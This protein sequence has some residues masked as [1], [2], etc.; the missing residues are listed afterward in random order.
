LNRSGHGIFVTV[1]QTDL[2]GRRKSNIQRIRAVFADLDGVPLEPVYTCKLEPH[3]VVESSPGNYHPYWFVDELPLNLFKP[4]QKTIQDRFDGDAVIDRSRVMRL[5]GFQHMKDPDNP[6]PV[7]IHKHAPAR[8]YTRDEITAVFP[9][10][11]NDRPQDGTDSYTGGSADRSHGS[12]TL[13]ETIEEGARNTTLTRYAGSIWTEEKTRRELLDDLKT[14]NQ[15]HCKP[16]LPE[17]ELKKITY[18]AQDWNPVPETNKSTGRHIKELIDHVGCIDWPNPRT[19]ETDKATFRALLEVGKQACSMTVSASIR[20]LSN[21]SGTALDT[22]RNALKRLIEYGLIAK[23]KEADGRTPAVYEITPDTIEHYGNHASCVRSNCTTVS[24]VGVD[25]L[26]DT[27]YFPSAL[28]RKARSIVHVLKEKARVGSVRKLAELADTT[29]RTVQRKLDTLKELDIVRT[30]HEPG[31]A[32]TVWL[33]DGWKT[34]LTEYREDAP[35]WLKDVDRRIKYK[36]DQIINEYE[37][38]NRQAGEL[39]VTRVDGIGEVHAP[40]DV[41]E[42]LRKAR[43]YRQRVAANPDSRE[44]IQDELAELQRGFDVRVKKLA[45]ELLDLIRER[46]KKQREKWGADD[47]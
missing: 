19:N 45:N 2:N 30:E 20:R 39:E 8:S 42:Y 3:L 35:S 33:T 47:D 28:G 29:T 5:P 31:Q 24:G 10:G 22:V 12:F 21:L 16:P 46:I 27:A 38:R 17:Y 40:S 44:E 18:S 14:V 23:Q 7:R 36:E 25:E 34:R 13:P 43:T 37:R 11:D 1:N 9:P 15:E 41:I 32:K 4:V 26:Q 6:H